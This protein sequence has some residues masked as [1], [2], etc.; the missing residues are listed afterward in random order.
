MIRAAFVPDKVQI[1]RSRYFK[2][3]VWKSLLLLNCNEII[4]D[5]QEKIDPLPT[6][7]K[8]IET[9]VSYLKTI[10]TT[11]AKTFAQRTPSP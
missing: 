9:P 3:G 11:I 2:F 1:V 4:K 6:E 7:S 5:E 10:C 8:L